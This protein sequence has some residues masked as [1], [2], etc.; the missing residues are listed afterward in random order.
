MQLIGPDGKPILTKESQE[1]LQ[2]LEERKKIYRLHPDV[3]A[4]CQQ[5]VNLSILSASIP[6]METINAGKTIQDFMLEE[7][8]DDPTGTTM[9][10]SKEWY[11]EFKKNIEG[12]FEIVNEALQ[13]RAEEAAKAA[14]AQEKSEEQQNLF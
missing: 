10:I 1:K 14:E 9:T 3:S 8:P 2:Q 11:E 4:L 6:D 5:V 13:K 12:A 7:S